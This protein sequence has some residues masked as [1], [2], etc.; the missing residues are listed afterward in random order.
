MNKTLLIT[1]PNHDITTRYLSEWSK[2]IIEIAG[3]KI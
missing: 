1:R 3:K 2:K